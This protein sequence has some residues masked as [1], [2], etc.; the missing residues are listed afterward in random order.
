MVTMIKLFLLKSLFAG[1]I[2]ILLLFLGALKSHQNSIY[3]KTA[4]HNPY[5]PQQ[6]PERRFETNVEGYKIEGKPAAFIN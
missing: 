1:K 2:A 5:F 6:Y 3:M 4:Q